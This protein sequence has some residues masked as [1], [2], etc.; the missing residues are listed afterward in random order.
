MLRGHRFF[1]GTYRLLW[2]VILSH[3]RPLLTK[4]TFAFWPGLLPYIMLS[5]IHITLIWY[6]I[7]KTSCPNVI[8]YLSIIPYT[9]PR[10]Q[11]KFHPVNPSTPSCGT[12]PDGARASGT[13]ATLKVTDGFVNGTSIWHLPTRSWF[14]AWSEVILG[15]WK[16]VGSQTF[17]KLAANPL[18]Q[19]WFKGHSKVRQ[20]YEAS[21][22]IEG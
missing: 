12:Q 18:P 9:I 5:W 17:L 19:K 1:L 21:I 13:H 14:T 3:L 2:F 20:H 15:G 16:Q 10:T 7:F 8:S 6:I 22:N 4:L 11:H